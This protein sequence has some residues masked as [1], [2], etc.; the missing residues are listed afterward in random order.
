LG[1]ATDVAL[2]VAVETLKFVNSRAKHAEETGLSGA[3]GATAP[4]TLRQK[5]RKP[6]A[7][8][9]VVW[10]LLRRFAV[11]RRGKSGSPMG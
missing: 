11:L 1:I 5:D 4:E 7:L 9:K 8:W 3:E 2:I 10:H 6:T